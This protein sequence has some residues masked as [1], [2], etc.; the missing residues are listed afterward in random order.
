MANGAKFEINVEAKSLGIDSSAAQLTAFAQKLQNVDTVATQFDN[1]VAASAKRLEETS[2]AAKLASDALAKAE[3]K[4]TGLEAAANR[5]AKAVEKAAA[6]GKDTAALKVAAEEAAAAMRA[7]TSVVDALA[8]KS[9]EAA[10]AQSELAS[11]LKTLQT[12]QAAASAEIKK[13][14]AEDAAA[15]EAA[16]EL[17]AA[18]L[19]DGSVKLEQAAAAKTLAAQEAAA[20]AAA[21]KAQWVLAAK[22]KVMSLAADAA[23]GMTEAIAGNVA[24]LGKFAVASNPAAMMRLNM[25]SQRL[26]LSFVQM[27]RGL[28][29]DGFTAGIQRLAGLFE[30]STASGRAMKILVET[31]FQ[32][33]FDAAAKL[34]PYIGEAFK[35]L[36][37]GVLLVVIAVLTLRN[38]IFKAMSPE[39]RQTIKSVVDKFFT[40]EN[41]FKVGE[42][43][44]GVLAV[45]VG[46]V[47][48]AI[49][50]VLVTAGLIAAVV[51]G[52]FVAIGV[53][54]DKLVT[55]V[56]GSWDALIDGAKDAAKSII[57]GIVD[58]IKN[59]AKWVY[60][61]INDL[62]DNTVKTFKSALKINSPSKVF[63]LQAEGIPEGTVDGI[64]GGSPAVRSALE[65]MVSPAD[66]DSGGI[67][68]IGAGGTSTSNASTNSRSIHIEHL[69][70]GGGSVAQSTFGD[71]KRALLEVLE[72]ASLTIGGGEAPAT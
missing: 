49:L 23:I 32:P 10:S 35:G 6:A 55:K 42:V 3:T 40:L 1:A 68:S 59:G 4:Y 56:A 58:G 18:G 52:P 41:A 26:H 51:I 47:A 65:S 44:A 45:A 50:G 25:I 33:L 21:S 22:V 31:I 34:E 70:I 24:A 27:F 17:Y 12:N 63:A 29:L 30:Q 66:I 9:R 14:V 69:T 28:N 43:A 46:L 13:A 36:I 8:V 39:L 60:D 16:D 62:A 5:T 72:G 37:H 71:L 57:N 64:E 48:I 38:A 53:A 11:T 15:I 67:R 20:T 54:I 19:H 61:A 7:Q 2:V